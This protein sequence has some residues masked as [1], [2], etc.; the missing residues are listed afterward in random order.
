MSALGVLC[1]DFA[2]L[3]SRTCTKSNTISYNLLLRQIYM[4]IVKP[5]M[6]TPLISQAS[7]APATPHY[8]KNSYKYPADHPRLLDP[9]LY[10]SIGI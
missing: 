3:Q 1:F 2:T 5:T 8:F 9:I 6:L 4:Y 10:K 7:I